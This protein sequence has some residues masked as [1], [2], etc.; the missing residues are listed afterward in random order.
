MLLMML[1]FTLGLVFS[2]ACSNNPRPSEKQEGPE[3]GVYYYDADEGEY[4]VSLNKG[5]QA[6]FTTTKLSVVGTYSV[7]GSTVTFNVPK[8]EQNGADKAATFYAKLADNALTVTYEET[9]CRFLK[10]VM[11]SVAFE[12]GVG[13][14]VLPDVSV[15]ERKNGCEACRSR[16]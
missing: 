3:S 8:S 15:N 2:A 11:Y 4:L 14:D 13:G 9:E 5:D 12:T 6:V 16:P 7:E 1:F 10:K